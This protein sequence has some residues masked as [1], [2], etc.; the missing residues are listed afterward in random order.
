MSHPFNAILALFI[1]SMDFTEYRSFKKYLPYLIIIPVFILFKKLTASEYES[2]KMNWIFDIE[3][4]KT[5]E[6]L[7]QQEHLIRRTQFLLNHYYV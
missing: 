4:N 6:M 7:F 1:L 2:G 3:H 5:Y